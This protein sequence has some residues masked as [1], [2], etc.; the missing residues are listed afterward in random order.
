[1][2]GFW[3]A[4]AVPVSLRKWL[5]QIC[6]VRFLFESSSVP[7]TASGVEQQNQLDFCKGIRASYI[8]KVRNGI[9][10]GSKTT[11]TTEMLEPRTPERESSMAFGCRT[12]RNPT[13]NTSVFSNNTKTR[14]RSVSKVFRWILWVRVGQLLVYLWI[15]KGAKQWG[16]ALPELLF[17]TLHTFSI[18][19][20]GHLLNWFAL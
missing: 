9:V 2:V 18:L 1:M 15:L 14:G 4:Q 3:F 16:R 13:W 7:K 12:P 19:V 20:V 17:W 6:F 5:V 11:I 8:W 10:F